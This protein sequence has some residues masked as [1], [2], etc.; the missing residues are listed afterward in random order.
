M[1]QK[2]YKKFLVVLKKIDK[3]EIRIK[4]EEFD[5]YF[6]HY[7]NKAYV[8]TLAVYGADEA[9]KLVREVHHS[10]KSGMHLFIAL[11]QKF[12]ALQK[13]KTKKELREERGKKSRIR[14]IY[15]RR[16]DESE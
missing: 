15:Y 9:N 4:T 7:L 10:N 5:M 14:K 13:L 6:K 12:I 11:K 16:E 2:Q 3:L 1:T 8:F